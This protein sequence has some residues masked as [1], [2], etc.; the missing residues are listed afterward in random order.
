MK[1][2]SY[3]LFVFLVLFSS[4]NCK[5]DDLPKPTQTGANI[6]AAKVNGKT[7]EKK[8]CWSCTGGGDGLIVDYDDRAF[9][10]VTGE[11]PDQ[12][13]IIALA[14]TS[15][16]STGTYQLT[17]KNLNFARLFKSNEGKYYFTSINNTGTVTI[18][19]LDLTKKII[20]GTF[21]LTAEDENNPANTIRVTGGRFDVT[22]F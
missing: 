2:F 16:K 13:L 3:I 6:M 14:I 5:K 21:E 9:F 10:A 7:W 4:F 8:A 12:G 22:F 11:D 19:K 1:T 20:S 15:L 17:S 18:T